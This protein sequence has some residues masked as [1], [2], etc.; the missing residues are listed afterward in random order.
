M[1]TIGDTFTSYDPTRGHVS[2]YDPE[3]GNLLENV[4][5]WV[6]FFLSILGRV[7]PWL[8]NW[9]R[10]II[11]DAAVYAQITIVIVIVFIALSLTIIRYRASRIRGYTAGR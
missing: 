11:H 2:P 9:V 10:S 6:Q 5:S 8:C 1:S 7:V 4:T 3:T